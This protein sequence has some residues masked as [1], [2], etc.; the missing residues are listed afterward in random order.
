[1]SN[2]LKGNFNPYW[3]KCAASFFIVLSLA[4][5]SNN[6]NPNQKAS[7]SVYP[8]S[9]TSADDDILNSFK[10]QVDREEKNKYK[11]PSLD[12]PETKEEESKEVTYDI[13]QRSDEQQIANPRKQ[14]SQGIDDL[15]SMGFGLANSKASE[16]VKNW[17]AARKITSEFSLG[18]G[19]SGIK[20]ASFDML[21]PL[22]DSEDDIVFTQLGF[23]RSNRFTEDYRNTLN[24]GLGYRHIYEK[25]LVG[26][27]TFYDADLTGHNS[28]LGVGVEA[29]VDY[30]KLAGNSYIRL[31]DW[32]KSPD[33]YDY[34]ERPANGWDLRADAYLPQYPQLGGKLMYEQYY[35]DNVGLF[36]SSNRQKDPSAATLG[37]NYTPIPLI[38]LST[39]YRQGQDGMSDTTFRLAFNFQLGV[40]LKK[41]LSPD[42][43]RSSRLL[44]NIK[45]DLVDRNNEIVMDFKKNELG[46]LLLPVTINNSP[47]A[48]V[49]FP[50]VFTGSIRNVT[51][52]G[53]ASQFALPYGGGGTASIILPAYKTTGIN[54]YS[55]KAVGSD[56]Y[57]HV[58]NSNEM[59]ITVT[60]YVL[61]IETS[62][63]TGLANGSDFVI[64]TSTLKNL[65]GEAI[66]NSDITWEVQGNA[67]VI[68]QQNKT[69]SSGKAFIKLSSRFA[70]VVR[71]SVKEHEGSQA[72]SEVNFTVDVST[73]KV[74]SVIA[75]PNS[76]IAN[77]VNTTDVVATIQ[78]EN[79]NIVPANTPVTWTTTA[80]TLSSASSVT[81]ANGQATVT[82]KTTTSGNITVTASAIK[83]NSTVVISATADSSTAKVVSI[84][85]SLPNVV[86]DNITSSVISVVVHD[87]NGAVVPANTPVTWT[88]NLGTLE[89]ATT[90]TDINGHATN[91]I[92]SSTSGVATITANAVKGGLTIPVTFTANSLTAKV[93]SIASSIPSVIADDLT[94][95]IITV[96]VHDANGSIVPANTA[97]TWT[98]NLGTLENATTYTDA[99]GKATNA[100]KSSVA[101][102][103]TVSSNAV[104][105]GLTIPVTF[106]VDSST[107]RIVSIGNSAPTAVANNATETTIIVEVR[108]VNGAVV[109]VNT[110]VSWK[111]D[112]GTLTNATTYTD[113]NGESTNTIKSSLAGF[114]HIT[115]SA[116]KGSLNTLLHFT[117]DG[118]TSSITSLIPSLTTL[119]ANGTSTTIVATVKDS[120]GN[121]VPANT[122]VT[123]TSS[124]GTLSA[125]STVTDVNGQ[126]SVNLISTV[127]GSATVQANAS[128]GNM[129]VVVNFTPDALTF[130]VVNIASSIPSLLADGVSSTVISVDIQDANGNKAPVN[131]IVNWGTNLGTLSNLT[132]VTDA[133]GHATISLISNTAGV[134]TI[135]ATSVAGGQTIPVTFTPSSTAQVFSVDTSVASVVANNTDLA[136]VSAVVHDVN[137][138]PVVGATVNWTTN[139]GTLSASSSVTNS[140]GIATVNLKGTVVGTATV[141]AVSDV[142]TSKNVT[143]DFKVDTTTAKIYSMSS[144]LSSII[145]DNETVGYAYAQLSDANGNPLGDGVTINWTASDKIGL[146]DETGNYT[147]SS[148]S[149]TDS[150]GKATI[151][152]F[153]AEI[154]N[155]TITASYNGVSQQINITVEPVD[156]IANLQIERS[157]INVGRSENIQIEFYEIGKLE[158]PT[159][160]YIGGYVVYIECIGGSLCTD[161]G[162][163]ILP[164]SITSSG[165]SVTLNIPALTQTGTIQ[166]RMRVNNGIWGDIQELRVY[167]E[168]N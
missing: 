51:W 29:A 116:A 130:H 80:G 78:D 48:R 168:A 134:A 58:V 124:L 16:S 75:T 146:L 118:S 86:S 81:D 22:V 88:T 165:G 21:I 106:T 96:E 117:A 95:S 133:A 131:T 123:W 3:K 91:S 44:H 85:S 158:K 65:S 31:S 161:N 109:P 140:S 43:V 26:V 97:V 77:G 148:N 166:F 40:E 14:G 28:R 112:L 162:V 76:I 102:V 19:E 59:Q 54:T 7:S 39:D 136:V 93:V 103:A 2:R 23:R 62:K 12:M 115:A 153:G 57:G 11:L 113:A 6:I 89:N 155:G 4:A 137:N 105:G 107:A 25:T 92:K 128:Q 13:G 132:S 129:N 74:I 126:T 141:N 110:P 10:K 60:P 82:L 99:N 167:P 45:Y 73:A 101:G 50:V 94:T 15:Q 63:T 111:T 72:Q 24:M 127:S 34:M 100:I 66:P 152:F 8:A 160:L 9:S 150:K 53:T 90:Y 108:D 79:G 87:L 61:T 36:G 5:C 41:Q 104:Q 20:T 55:L 27:N 68:E 159:R 143:V 119:S 67:T 154:G 49:S 52:V 17:L 135:S 120:N 144:S 1:M 138:Q 30:L 98:T 142:V 83:G 164:A 33:M 122:P 151:P 70:S 37:I 64:F 71:V 149:I 46:T 69:N 35:G 38:T 163:D 157:S 32:K 56:E 125:S 121:I 156:M 84:S 18:A 42:E 147:L 47:N 114:A 139:L 145:S